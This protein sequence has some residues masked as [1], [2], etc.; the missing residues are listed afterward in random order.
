MNSL[1]VCFA[2]ASRLSGW[3]SSASIELERSRAMTMLMPSPRIVSIRAPVRGRAIA[4]TSAAIAMIRSSTSTARPASAPRASGEEPGA[5]VQQRGR[6]AA[7]T[8]EEPD[9]KGH[10]ERE[11]PRMRKGEGAERH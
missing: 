7:P 6:V 3:K 11:G 2:T 9:H 1:A 5:G 4:S 10:G 8:P